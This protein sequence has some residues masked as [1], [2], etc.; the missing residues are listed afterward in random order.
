MINFLKIKLNTFEWG[1]QIFKTIEFEKC[2]QSWKFLFNYI[3]KLIINN[4]LILFHNSQK[5]SKMN[6]FKNI[7]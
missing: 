1:F 7:T 2:N 6:F 4:I 5:L 3:Y